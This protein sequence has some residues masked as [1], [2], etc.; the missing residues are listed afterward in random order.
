MKSVKIVQTVSFIY[1]I[2]SMVQCMELQGNKQN[3]NTLA[4][5]WDQTSED[6]SKYRPGYPDDYFLLLQKLDIGLKE[7][8]YS[9]HRDGNRS[10]GS[11]I[12]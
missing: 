4:L 8:R 9:G 11:A 7:S 1:M 12:R 5:H 3:V 10:A 2:F 6:Y